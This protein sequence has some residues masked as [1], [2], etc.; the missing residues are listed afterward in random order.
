[1]SAKATQAPGPI[2]QLRRAAG[3]TQEAL[4]REVGCSTAYVRMIEGGYE[5]DP[6]ASPV[7]A[8]VL[9]HLTNDD[10]ADQG[11]AVKHGEAAPH[12]AG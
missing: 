7:F 11:E 1:M 2:R 12:D 8:R 5:P 3:L 10:P 9:A 6:G 4:A